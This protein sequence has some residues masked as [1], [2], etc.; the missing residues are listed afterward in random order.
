MTRPR[1]T[2]A[3][4]LSDRRVFLMLLLGF[5]SG[6]PFLL[7]FSTL[8]ARLREVGIAH[9]S[10]GLLSY[11]ALAY[12]FK[13]VWA[14]VVDAFDVP[15][16]SRLL[17]R[18]RGWMVLSQLAVAAGLVGIGLSD[19]KTALLATV[20]CALAV[21]FASATQDV[22]IDGWRIN[23]AATD[24]Q[25]MLA[26]AYQLGYRLALLAAGA[27]A[28]L[29]ADA[30][31]W[32]A[33][34]VAMA[35]CMGIGLVASLL[36]PRADGTRDPASPR[37]RFNLAD[38]VVEPL[39]DLWRR[40]G[41]VLALILTLVMLFRLPDFVAG[42]MANPLYID[43]G[44]TK[45]D[46]AWVSKIF[47]VWVGI[48]GAFA[49][50]LLL[51]RIGLKAALVFGAA[52][53]AGSNVMFALLALRGADLNFL[54]LSISIDNFAGGFAGTALIAYMSGLTSPAFAA[55]QYALLSSL[56]AL[57]GKLVGGVSGFMVEAY[58]YPVFFTLTAAVGIPVV[59][60]AFLVAREEPR[61]AEDAVPEG[62]ARAEA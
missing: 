34:Y 15:V 14:P 5:S 28:L 33:A 57:P 35:A 48:A 44:F 32:T 59:I 39:A 27:G 61:A 43:M 54:I 16:L 25:A 8:S 51:P 19:P 50:G 46:I 1:L 17:G 40:K 55:T 23:V 41:P 26:A 10:I 31:N 18:R 62:A 13:F 11:V 20:L 24:R 9:S 30:V 42:V 6:L 7:V 45:T 47:G 37:P 56:Y 2:L 49:A 22:V 53:S 21:A 3:E 29:V 36:A 52:A 60:L 58:G 12:S 4:T 38:A